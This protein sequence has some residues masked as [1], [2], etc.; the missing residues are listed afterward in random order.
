MKATTAMRPVRNAFDPSARAVFVAYFGLFIS[1]SLLTAITS[2]RNRWIV[3]A[4]CTAIAVPVSVFVSVQFR[5]RTAALNRHAANVGVHDRDQRDV[6]VA[7]FAGLQA[8]EAAAGRP[9]LLRVLL[10]RSQPSKLILLATE[11]SAQDGQQVRERIAA[12]DLK[13]LPMVEM[14]VIPAGEFSNESL[15]AR[16]RETLDDGVQPASVVVDGTGAT[17]IMSVSAFAAAVACGID[18]Q[19]VRQDYLAVSVLPA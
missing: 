6:L 11:R 4:L 8:T 1:P 10:E 9:A 17:A 15:T 7:T 18:F 12:W 5:R 13:V 3:F 19:S 14:I 16:L 2:S